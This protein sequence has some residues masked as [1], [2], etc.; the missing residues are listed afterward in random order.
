ML[1]F[2]AA[3]AAEFLCLLIFVFD[4]QLDLFVDNILIRNEVIFVI[5]QK[6]EFFSFEKKSINPTKV[7]D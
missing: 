1:S 4:L 6:I 7:T 3:S 2:L 5:V